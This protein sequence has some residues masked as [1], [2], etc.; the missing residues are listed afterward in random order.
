[1]TTILMFQLVSAFLWGIPL[2]LFAPSVVR[3]WRSTADALDIIVSPFAFGAIVQ[4]GFTLR[5]LIFPKATAHM[6]T[7]ELL[8][9]SGLYTL[10]GITAL[11]AAFAWRVARGTR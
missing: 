1:M 4:I 10:S 3:I 5:W 9:W 8:M 7:N 2:A 6:E 11:G